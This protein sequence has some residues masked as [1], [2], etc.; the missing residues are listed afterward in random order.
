VSRPSGILLAGGASRRFGRP[1]ILEPLDGSPLF[2]HPL[3]ALAAVCDEVL[4]VIAPDGPEVAL[5]DGVAR[6][7][8]VRDAVSHGGPLLG[9]VTGLARARGE[10]A[11]LA[12]ADQPR[13]RPEL[14][15]LMVTRAEASARG[16]TVLADDDGTR[17]LPAVLRV[18]AA[19]SLAES[20]VREGE[21][22][23]RALIDGLD[24]EV[25]DETAWSAAD[26]AGDWRRDVD[27][28]ED[29]RRR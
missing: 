16:A 29:L 3:R 20:L 25:L 7:R 27:V 9:T 22:R 12:A 17:P 23:L 15:T 18:R 21:R 19:L 10:H 11:V 13:L 2:H 28:P 6:V 5:P 1:K 24:P 8:F 14:L 26:P 4:V